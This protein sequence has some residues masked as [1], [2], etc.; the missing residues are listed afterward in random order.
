M[1]HVEWAAQHVHTHLPIGMYDKSQKTTSILVILCLKKK[2]EKKIYTIRVQSINPWLHAIVCV[3]WS[4]LT[5]SAMSAK[6]KRNTKITINILVDH[7]DRLTPNGLE[8]NQWGTKLVV[9]FQQIYLSTWIPS[10]TVIL[11][12][13]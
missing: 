6:Q 8:Y 7:L 2:A 13:N 11:S 12:L 10:S 5:D 9:F 1:L 4:A 3:L